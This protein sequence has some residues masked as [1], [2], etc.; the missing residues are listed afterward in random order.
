[1]TAWPIMTNLL[2]VTINMPPGIESFK[3]K[4]FLRPRRGHLL[5]ATGA[6][7]GKRCEKITPTP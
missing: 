1:M 6:T 3:G 2:V 4:V 7:G 5:V